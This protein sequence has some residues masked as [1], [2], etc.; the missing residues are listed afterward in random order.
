MLD[1]KKAYLQVH[2]VDQL[3]RFHAVRYNGHI[4]VIARI[5]FGLTNTLKPMSRIISKVLA[6]DELMERGTDHYI[7]DIWVD[8]GVV[9][10][11]KV[12]SLMERYGLTTKE[13][14]PLSDARVLGLRVEGDR[15]GS[16]S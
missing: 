14:V 4:C 2:I 12:K 9:D 7:D 6:L 1:L 8:E 13:P 5:G 11:K 15:E 16:K 10:V 3:K